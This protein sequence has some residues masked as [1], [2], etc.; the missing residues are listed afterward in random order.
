MQ[1][2]RIAFQATDGFLDN[3]EDYDIHIDNVVTS[4]ISAV[5][6]ANQDRQYGI[7]VAPN[8]CFDGKIK[9]YLAGEKSSPR[10]FSV[11]GKEFFPRKID[12]E[13]NYDVAELPSGFYLI[14]LP[15][16]VAPLI[17]QR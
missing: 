4:P 13:G 10:F 1:N 5:D 9:L 15:E 2:C 3:P 6:N 7:Q 14:R 11:S 17:I 12:E 16:A 8:P